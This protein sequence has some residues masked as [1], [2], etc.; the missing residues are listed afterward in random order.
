MGKK[1]LIV[2]SPAK[3][4][5]IKKFLGKEYDVASSY[6][7]IADL[8]ENEMGIDI[9]QNFKPKYIISP[10][11]KK[12]ISQ[13]RK[14]AENS[15]TVYLASDE[16]REG[17]AIAWHLKN[18]LQLDEKAQRIVFHEI[19]EKAIKEALSN[20]RDINQNLVNAQQARRLLDRLVG[21]RLSPVLWKKIK[22]G[23]S[24]GRVQS[25]A[26]RLI[27]E[28]EKEI[29]RFKPEVSY[30][31]EAQFKKI[32]TDDTFKAHLNKELISEKEIKEFFSSLNQ[33]RFQV[34]N[35]KKKKGKRNPAPP[36]TTSTLQQE[37]ATKL[38][39]SVSRT[40]QIAQYLYENG[41]I[42]YMRTDSV[43]LSEVAISQA[44]EY[45]INHYGKEYSKPKQ[46]KTKSKSAQ[47]AHEAIR[48]TNIFNDN[49]H[50]DRD[51]SRLYKLIW[52]RT[53]ASQM[54][55][56]EIEHTNVEIS[57]GLS[58]YFFKAKG[59]VMI[60][61]GFLKIYLPAD[62][63]EGDKQLPK[64][65][66]G[67]SLETIQILGKEKY[68]KPNPRYNEASLV[69]KLEELGIGRPSTY[70][71]TISIIQ[72]RGYVVKKTIP[73]KKKN[74]KIWEWKNGKLK[75]K[76]VKEAYGGEKNKLIP[77]DIGIIV[78]DFLVKNF[79]EIVDYGFTAQVETQFDKI[80]AGKY[81]WLKMIKNFYEGFSP[82]V[83]KVTKES[84]KEKGERLLGKDPESGK[85]VYA[86]YGPYGPMVQL[87]EASETEKPQYASLLPG[88][89]IMEITLEEALE[90]FKLPKKIGEY[91]NQEVVLGTGKYG[92]YIRHGNKFISVPAHL[93]I[94]KMNL[95]DAISVIEKKEKQD[96]PVAEIDGKPV[97]VMTGKYGPYLKWNEMNIKIPK[98]ISP[99][100]L[101]KETINKLID[102][103]L[104][105]DKEN[106]LKEWQ[107]EGISLRKG[108]W[109]RIYIYINGK[110]KKLLPKNFDPEKVQLDEIKK[111]AGIK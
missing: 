85:N 81:D 2:E 95:E 30:K 77:T 46:Y 22:K 33:A 35:I 10:D 91:D 21:Y 84:K 56:A 90:L 111:I 37:A 71:P 6:G 93:N 49:P 75:E 106:T 28:R 76:T 12:I 11:K 51:A 39:F 41:F 40:M 43:N 53:V 16:D 58:D 52:Y 63:A 61:D 92:P 97:Y 94:L 26:L 27:V 83:E 64:L 96:K 87:G 80:A 82:L 54:S 104:K 34:E 48:P 79:P 32:N 107:K 25:V 102:E 98:N 44:Q 68:S 29:L 7:H 109:G 105:K 24:A 23:L 73:S 74:I 9:D 3:A 17:E 69:K 88:M 55:P 86:K 19:T 62:Y 14:L 4:K 66:K 45:I 89:T 59:E 70:A 13:L 72:K 36:F 20:P 103:K 99:Q 38:G 57:T 47:E 60:F 15:E 5:T 67:E 50:L 101:D 78:N 108:G 31:V 65:K 100:N 42:T 18:F 8:P 1:L 110:R